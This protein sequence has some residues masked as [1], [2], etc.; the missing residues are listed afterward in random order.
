MRTTKP[1]DLRATRANRV[2]C[3]GY[4]YIGRLYLIRVQIIQIVRSPLQ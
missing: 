1:T 4:V 2:P 3:V